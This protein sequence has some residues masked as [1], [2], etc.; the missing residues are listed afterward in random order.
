MV[1]VLILGHQ[2]SQKDQGLVK[3]MAADHETVDKLE[4]KVE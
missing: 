3:E 4:K 2:G 1:L